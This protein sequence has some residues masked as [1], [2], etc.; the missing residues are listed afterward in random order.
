MPYLTS[1]PSDARLLDVFRAFP[2]TARPLLDYHEALMRGPSPLTVGER[3]L[4]AAFVSALNECAYCHGV[5]AATARA[6]GIDEAV[7][8]GLVDGVEASPLEPR[9]K[10]LLRYVEKVTRTPS[11]I[12]QAD[13]DA[14][15]AAGW[16]DAE[17]HD[18]VS[19]AGLFNLMN[20]LV[21]GLGIRADDAYTE[22]A[23]RRLAAPPGYAGLADL[24]PP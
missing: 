2:A 14:V 23:A 21:D 9:L 8:R 7:L 6:F 18:A 12:S 16:D 15:R 5:H 24:L 1:L 13:A 22:L 17:L 3:E 11:R 10:P 4:I 20:R 19:V